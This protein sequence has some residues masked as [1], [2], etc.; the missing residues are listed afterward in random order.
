MVIIYILD[1]TFDEF[2]ESVYQIKLQYFEAINMMDGEWVF[3]AL[4][5]CLQYR[6]H[7]VKESFSNIKTRNYSNNT[8]L[9]T[10]YV[11]IGVHCILYDNVMA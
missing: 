1:L 8:E 5:I 2:R 10:P 9:S 7:F 3:V 11:C 6:N 4:K